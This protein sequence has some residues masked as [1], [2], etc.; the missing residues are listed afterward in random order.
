MP[1]R[2]P[3]VRAGHHRSGGSA[4]NPVRPVRVLPPPS[5]PVRRRL[6]SADRTE[7]DVSGQTGFPAHLRPRHDPHDRRRHRLP[8]S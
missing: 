6:R 4:W 2:P 5:F 7:L 1:Q 3:P 8:V